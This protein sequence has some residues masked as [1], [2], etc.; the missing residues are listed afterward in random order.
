M[1]LLRWTALTGVALSGAACNWNANLGSVGDGP[2]SL[3]WKATFERGDLSEWTAGNLGGTDVAN[4]SSSPTVAFGSFHHGNGS[5]SAEIVIVPT[6]G[7]TSISYLYRQQPSP[8]AAYY[9]A[10]FYVPGN[11]AVP[12][13]AY[14]SLVHFRGSKTPDGTELYA[15]WD[16]NLYTQANGLLAAQ[17]YDFKDTDTQQSPPV[18]AFPTD[19]WVQ[20]E[21]FLSK[22][23]P[24]DA[25]TPTGKIA[26]WQNG[27]LI[28]ERQGVSTVM[29]DFLEWN[30]GGTSNS[31]SPIPAS[32]YLD[33]AAISLVR[34]GPNASL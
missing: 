2:A 14:L 25:G 18:I 11:I 28:L 21:V 24:T 20:L 16:I 30:V 10:W 13:G 5:H 7:M 27:Q 4:T 23:V 1:R 34:L 3:L 8:P 33:D 31:I 19:E 26:V 22:A 15:A 32:I 17:L 29:N 6:L 12:V 9:S